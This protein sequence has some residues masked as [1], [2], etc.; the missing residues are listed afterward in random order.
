MFRR[1]IEVK[2]NSFKIQGSR[3]GSQQSMQWEKVQG[4]PAAIGYLC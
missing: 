3:R 4:N 1:H 2:K